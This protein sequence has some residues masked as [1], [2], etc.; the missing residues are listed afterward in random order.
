[1]RLGWM[2]AEVRG[3]YR[4]Q[5][6]PRLLAGYNRS[7]RT[8]RAL[9]LAAERS[10]AEQRI[11]AERVL[12]ALANS[13]HV[14]YP[15][16]A[17]KINETLM[18]LPAGSLGASA[19]LVCDYLPPLG[20]ALASAHNQKLPEE[21]TIWWRMAE[22][23]YQW[24]TRIQDDLASGPYGLASA[25][26][27]GRGLAEVYWA[28][29][30]DAPTGDPAS[31]N[32]LL[33]DQRFNQL[34][35]LLRRVTPFLPKL[36][37]ETITATLE[38]W[39]AVASSATWRNKTDALTALGLQSALWRDLLLS[40][41]PPEVLVTTTDQTLRRAR[42]LRP[43][44]ASFAGEAAV[45]FIGLVFVGGAVFV[46]LSAGQGIDKVIGGTLGGVLG[47]FGVTWSALLTRAKVMGQGILN[48][49][50]AKVAADATIIA[51]TYL[52]APTRRAGIVSERLHVTN[53]RR[54]GPVLEYAETPSQRI[55]RSPEQQVIG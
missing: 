52:P 45:L 3:R 16:G 38:Q 11:E 24:D 39:H 28:L 43:L 32:H 47:L 44:I 50:R 49:L 18:G 29:D 9:P 6:D 23:F 2:V 27:V 35:T 1:M 4:L 21:K 48:Q 8:G 20:M 33:G 31:W 19:H 26:Q 5:N 10:P 12:I 51:A 14:N 37:G 22:L 7:D 40:A 41:S 55:A 36:T 13:L 53:E 25:Y 34:A 46:A 15:D 30:P 17:L 54:L 42:S